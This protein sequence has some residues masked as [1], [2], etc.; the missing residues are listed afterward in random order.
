MS[1]LF[2]LDWTNIKSA[3][4]SGVLTAILGGAGYVIGL[5]NIFS[6]DIHT[7]ANIVVLAFLVAVVSLIKQLLT[8]SQG[9]FVGAV[10]VV[11][12]D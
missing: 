5:G 6:V 2:K 1:G 3:L 11:S 12:S 4:V 10:N 7:L 9:N 8:T